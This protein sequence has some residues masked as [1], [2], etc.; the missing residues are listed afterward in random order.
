V[1]NST[2]E[3]NLQVLQLRG[4]EVLDFFLRLLALFITALNATQ[5]VFSFFFFFF[6]F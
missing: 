2:F 1:L 5:K 6:F 4:Y 3:Q